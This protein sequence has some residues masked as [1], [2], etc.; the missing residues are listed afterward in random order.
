MKLL[1]YGHKYSKF[2]WIFER[3]SDIFS[4]FFPKQLLPFGS[5]GLESVG[6][7]LTKPTVFLW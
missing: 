2:F 6:A 1:G 7:Y 4:R 5:L 3:N